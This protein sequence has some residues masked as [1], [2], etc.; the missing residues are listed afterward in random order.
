MVIY[1]I[2]GK[3]QTS[4]GVADEAPL[5]YCAESEMLREKPLK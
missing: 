4:G 5:I 3:D 2:L 1:D